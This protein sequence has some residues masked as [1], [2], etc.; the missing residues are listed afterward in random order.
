[1]EYGSDGVSN[2]TAAEEESVDMLRWENLK[3]VEFG[4]R[5]TETLNRYIKRGWLQLASHSPISP[6]RSVIEN[7]S[8][9]PS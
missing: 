8:M 6:E 1:M 3:K 7:R 4:V 5:E 9:L 2:S